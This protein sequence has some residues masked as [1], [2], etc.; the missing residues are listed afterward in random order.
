MYHSTYSEIYVIH[1]ILICDDM[2][3]T[4]YNI[5]QKWVCS[6]TEN[7]IMMFWSFGKDKWFYVLIFFF[8]WSCSCTYHQAEISRYPA[9]L[10]CTAYNFY[11]KRIRVTWLRNGQ[12]VTSGVSCSEVM[13]NGNWY[14]QIHS[15]LEYMPSPHEEIT[16]MVE[17]ASLSKPVF[18]VWGECSSV[19]QIVDNIRKM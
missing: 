1:N 14:Y 8:R 7:C 18:H 13:S 17:H 4:A 11:P 19:M 2:T 6:N 10:M 5:S 3:C 12:E 15:Y 9:M 16:C